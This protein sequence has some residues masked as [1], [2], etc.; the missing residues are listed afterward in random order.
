[1]PIASETL[2]PFLTPEEQMFMATNPEA[3]KAKAMA[4]V[5]R[6]ENRLAAS[7]TPTQGSGWGAGLATALKGYAGSRAGRGLAKAK[8]AQGAAEADI[9]RKAALTKTAE[10][11]RQ[12]KLIK[13][14]AA[15][16][17]LDAIALQKI[18]ASDAEKGGGLE[19]LPISAKDATYPSIAK[20]LEAKAN[21]ASDAEV[22]AALER[23]DPFS[24]HGL[25][26]KAD[27]SLVSSDESIQ[28]S[29]DLARQAA[30]AE[31]IGKDFG[32]NK[33]TFFNDLAT[34]NRGLGKARADQTRLAKT[35]GKASRMIADLQG[36]GWSGLLSDLPDSE[37]KKL[38]NYL[39]TIRANSAFNTL[40]EMRE[41]SK[42]GGALGQVSEIEIKLLM[43][44]MGSLDQ[45]GDPQDLLDVLGELNEANEGA[46]TRWE[47]EVDDKYNRFRGIP[48][49]T[50][51][52]PVSGQ[53]D[54]GTASDEDLDAA[55]AAAVAAQGGQGGNP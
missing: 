35:I 22:M 53:L 27:G 31:A 26:K 20:A 7:Q 4:D 29:I 12:E 41:A 11:L 16:K 10:K 1:M 21:G 23:Y 37:A 34:I 3:A 8:A 55:I 15:Q 14:A 38:D 6:G 44:A 32:V 17:Q 5:L 49:E 9:L 52:E 51:Q 40:S 13:E 47:T 24:E 39:E 19:V 2:N 48:I 18:K 43:A 45:R 36:T 54:L 46:I 30:E 25:R 28:Q 50:D 33:E 42:T